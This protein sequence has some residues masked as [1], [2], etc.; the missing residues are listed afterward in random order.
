MR[1]LILLILAAAI[2]ITI[3]DVG[4]VAQATYPDRPIWAVVL[5]AD[6]CLVIFLYRNWKS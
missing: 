5:L 3:A 6:I 1:K 2:F 4:A